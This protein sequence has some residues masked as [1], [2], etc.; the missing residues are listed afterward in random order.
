MK[1]NVD[2]TKGMRISKQLSLV[3]IMTDQKQLE[4]VEY[5]NY[6]VSLITKNTRWTSETKSRIFMAKAEFNRRKKKKMKKKKK[7]KKKKKTFSPATGLNFKEE[8]SENIWS[9]VRM[10]LES[11]RFGN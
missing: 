9:V 8:T 7:K 3:Q 4:S 1:M 5:F 10:V 2:K 11:W 6:F